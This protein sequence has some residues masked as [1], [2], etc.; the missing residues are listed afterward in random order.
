MLYLYTARFLRSLK[1][2]DEEVQNDV[3]RAVSLFEKEKD[4]ESLKF[5]KL[6]GKFRSWYAFSANFTYRV[7]IK[8]EKDAIYYL[9]VGTHDIY[10]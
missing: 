4:A 5:H 3:F 8:K 7:I 1:K 2:C 6:H 9:D 10:R